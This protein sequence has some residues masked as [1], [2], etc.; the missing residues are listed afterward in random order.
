MAWAGGRSSSPS[1]PA[2]FSSGFGP[3]RVEPYGV[4]IAGLF[5]IAYAIYAGTGERLE[6]Q[7]VGPLS[8]FNATTDTAS[9]G[10]GVYAA[11]IGGALI[12]LGGALLAGWGVGG[13]SAEDV[14]RT[15]KCPDCAETVQADARVCKHCGFRFDEGL[16]ESR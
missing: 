5:G 12:A 4:L 2:S 15:K 1:Q 7:S 14:R 16:G 8:G 3:R 9:P 6:L 11:G 10:V 13:H